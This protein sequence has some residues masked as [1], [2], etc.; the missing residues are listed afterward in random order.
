MLCVLIKKEEFP[1]A[2]IVGNQ[3]WMGIKMWIPFHK[4]NEM[5]KKWIALVFFWDMGQWNQKICSPFYFPS[6]QLL[7][8]HFKKKYIKL[9]IFVI[10]MQN[11]NPLYG[12]FITNL[13]SHTHQLGIS[14]IIHIYAAS[15]QSLQKQLG[16]INIYEKRIKWT[17]IQRLC[18]S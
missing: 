13:F 16:K 10:F 12:Y 2:W 11:N 7:L 18:H 17:N 14:H 8:R 6:F 4:W 3:M 1:N 5:C 9:F 15:Y